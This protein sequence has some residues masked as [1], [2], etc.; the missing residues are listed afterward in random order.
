MRDIL[1]RARKGAAEERKMLSEPICTMSDSQDAELHDCLVGVQRHL[2]AYA[3]PDA[4]EQSVSDLS[5]QLRTTLAVITLLSGN[6]DLLY[7]RLSDEQR[8]K[9]IRDIRAHTQKLNEFIDSV[10]AL[11]HSKGVAAM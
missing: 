11:C 1:W 10:L 4:Y 8:Q 9:I 3:E 6:L 2:V 7:G 5:H